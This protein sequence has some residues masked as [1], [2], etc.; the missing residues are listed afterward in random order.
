MGGFVAIRIEV[1]DN[2]KL[3]EYSYTEC[4]KLYLKWEVVG[5]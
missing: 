3:Q 1:G 2:V 5:S 4:K